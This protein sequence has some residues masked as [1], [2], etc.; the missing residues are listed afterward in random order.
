MKLVLYVLCY[1]DASEE[2]ARERFGK[3]PWATILRLHDDPRASKF[4]EGAAYLGALKE[5]RQEWEHADYVGTVAWRATDKIRILDD[6]DAHLERA[7]PA[8]VVAFL[9]SCESLVRMAVSCHPRFLEIWTPLL[10]HMGYD[11]QDTL[12]HDMPNFC[13]NYWVAS[14]DWLARFMDFYEQAVERLETL[15]SIQEALWSDA[16][17]TTKLGTER[18]LEI[19][20]KPYIP[21]HP[22]VSE[23]LACFFFW[24]EEARVVLMSLGKSEFWHK[25]YTAEMEDV[26]ARAHHMSQS[27]PLHD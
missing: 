6:L 25:H 10:Q 9:P 8:D 7:K 23:R 3:H 5:R 19:Y 14:P 17:Y 20:K 21:Y 2:G 18:C 15:P 12:R 24:R 11:A 26:A 4:M 13:C 22:F 27:F 16:F 1:D